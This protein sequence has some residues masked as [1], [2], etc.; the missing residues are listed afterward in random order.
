VGLDIHA[1]STPEIAVS[2]LA[3]YIQKRAELAGT[4]P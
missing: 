2:V 4:K 3:Q 1:Q